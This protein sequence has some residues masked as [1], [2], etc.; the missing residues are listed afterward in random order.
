M[1]NR[2]LTLQKTFALAILLIGIIGIAL[3][4]ATDFT[5]RQ[6]AYEQQRDSVTRL[7]ALKA[8]DLI[9]KSVNLQ[10]EI[11][12]RPQNQEAFILA[13]RNEDRNR[14]SELL[15]QEFDRYSA[16]TGLLKPEKILV[17]SPDFKLV[18]SSTRGIELDGKTLPC[19][20]LLKQ[21]KILPAPDRAKP[22]SQLCEYNEQPLLAGL[23]TVGEIKPEAYIQLI[24]SPAHSLIAIE[25]ELGF[26]L[27]I[28]NNR[29]KLLYRSINWPEQKIGTKCLLSNY[30]IRDRNNRLTLKI[31]AASD[32][33]DFKQHLDDIRYRVIAGSSI[34]TLL[35]LLIAL[36]LLQ[37]GLAPLKKLQQA[38]SRISKGE[39]VFINEDGYSEV[40][41]PI[42]AFNLMSNKIQSLINDLRAE[43]R[44]HRK[45]EKKLKKARDNAE[46]HARHTE[47]QS[48]FLQMTLQ[49]IVDGVITTTIDGYVQTINPMAEQLTGWTEEEARGKPLVLVMHALKEDTHKRIYD[50]TENIEYKTMLDEPVSAILIQK[51]TNIETPVE[52]VAAPMRDPDNQ[53]A[54]IVIIIHDESVQRSLNR[55][56]TFQATH[57]A[58][59]GL[60]NR[61]EFE[62]RLKNVISRQLQDHSVNTLCYIDLD[63]FKLVNDT[64]G[65]TAGDELL[66]N[67]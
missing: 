52:Y 24:T 16:T 38:A 35:T 65:H 57:D 44:N 29:D 54:G 45:T 67:L 14:L 19:Q 37:R 15:D 40:S 36:V 59:T 55:Q 3:V 51:N 43:A 6:L 56:L 17:F 33:T 63:Q 53:I 42:R 20:Q 26:P 25:D 60:I 11:A 58:L 39:F 23:F 8:N 50:P 61:Y 9:T 1:L 18:A 66:R 32:I 30:F 46:Q 5:Y 7:I 62:R 12:D 49:S 22:G 41:A 34:L 48:N 21:P 47:R 27:K 28:F 4:I 64:C 2:R 13:L 10:Q 31:S